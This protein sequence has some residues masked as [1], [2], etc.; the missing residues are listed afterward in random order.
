MPKQARQAS[1]AEIEFSP[2]AKAYL[3]AARWSPQRRLIVTAYEAAYEKEGFS[4]HAAAR[5]FLQRFGGLIIKYQTTAD[6]P[7]VLDF[8][9]DD[10]VRGMGSGGLAQIE[11]LLGI[12]PLCPLGHYQHGTCMLLQ[13]GDG[14]VFGVADDTVTRLAKSGEEAVNNILANLD[15]ELIQSAVASRRSRKGSRNK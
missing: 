3:R 5:R 10:A 8:C 1:R 7:D 4:L 9:A 15:V 14:R 6:Q 2:I 12:R 11:R 13:A